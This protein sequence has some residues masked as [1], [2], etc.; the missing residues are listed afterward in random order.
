MTEGVIKLDGQDKPKKSFYES[1][2]KAKK[3]PC[4]HSKDSKTQC[5]QSSN[6]RLGDVSAFV[7]SYRFQ[8]GTCG[9][10]IVKYSMTSCI[11]SDFIY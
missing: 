9:K 4:R 7:S 6:E 3:D 10:S 1:L 11:K 5:Q 2:P 8:K